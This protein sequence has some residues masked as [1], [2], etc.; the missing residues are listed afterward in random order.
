MIR[1]GIISKPQVLLGRTGG[2]Y[3]CA[4]NTQVYCAVADESWLMTEPSLP[5]IGK[6]TCEI[7]KAFAVET[8]E[9][10]EEQHPMTKIG[11]H[12]LFL[13]VSD[14]MC[15][16][17]KAPRSNKSCIPSSNFKAKSSH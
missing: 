12:G 9:E 8:N 6:S 16:H 17:I 7:L 15:R 13:V 3:V 4:T 14:D 10:V 11:H 5:I 1:N 2:L